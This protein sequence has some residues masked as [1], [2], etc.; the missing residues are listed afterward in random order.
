MKEC[1]TCD[2]LFEP[3]NKVQNYCCRKCMRRRKYNCANCDKSIIRVKRKGVDNYFCTRRC[4]ALFN[5]TRSERICEQCDIGFEIKTSALRYGYGKY[6]SNECHD[7][8]MKRSL[9]CMCPT[10]GKLFETGVNDIDRRIFCTK[11]CFYT[12]MMIDIPENE[13]R[14]LYIDKNLTTREI[15]PMYNTDK[16]V[17]CD[18]LDRYDIEIRPSGFYNKG[19]IRC[20]NG[21]M[22]RSHYERAFVNAMLTHDVDFIY[23]PRLP[24]DKRYSADFLVGD[25][26]VEVWG[27]IGWDKYDKRKAKKKKLYKENELNLFSVYPDDFKDVYDKVIELKRL[28][29]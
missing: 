28:I 3:K 24:F 22:V 5:G 18:Y 10:C 23:E 7:E 25:V 4:S 2:S 27:M 20:K 19:Y 9:T 1:L 17:I 6:C 15:A 8:S 11:E 21:L 29:A 13:L 12:S 14:K 26:Y 16:K